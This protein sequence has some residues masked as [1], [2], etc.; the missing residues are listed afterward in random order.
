MLSR[1]HTYIILSPLNPLLYIKTGVYR[2]IHYFS[3]FCSKH[4]LWVP[5][6]TASTSTH[7]LCFVQKYEKYLSFLSENFQFLERKFS[8]YLNRRVFVMYCMIIIIYSR[9]EIDYICIAL[10]IFYFNYCHI[11]IRKLNIKVKYSDRQ[12]WANST[13]I[14]RSGVAER[15][16]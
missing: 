10:H 8:L 7:N 2:G 3:Y 13:C 1:K 15:S 11:H 9:T 16:V 4:R 6:R 14:L 12:A 5:V